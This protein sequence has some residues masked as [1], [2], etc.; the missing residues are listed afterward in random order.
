MSGVDQ[1]PMQEHVLLSPLPAKSGQY[2]QCA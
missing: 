1:I 2:N